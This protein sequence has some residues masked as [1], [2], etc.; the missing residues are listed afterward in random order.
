MFRGKAIVVAGPRQV[1]KTT[2]LKQITENKDIKSLLLNCDDAEVRELLVDINSKEIF[3]LIGSNRIVMID[4]AQ[5]VK[6]IGLTIKQ[7]VDNMPDLQLI[8]TGSSSLDLANEIN[9]PLTG[10]K[11][12]Y[13]LFPFSVK[14]LVDSSNSLIEKQLLENRLIFGTYP[15][16]VNHP[17]EE[18]E[19]LLNIAESYLYKDILA[20]SN[21]RKP[22]QLEKL[23]TALA[24]QIGNEVSYNEL[25]QTVGANVETIERYIDLLEQCYVVFKQVAFSRNLRNEIKKSKKIYFYD[26]GIRNALISNFS[27]LALRQDTGQLWENYFVVERTKFNHY[28]LNFTKS[29]FWRTFQQQEIDLVEEIDEKLTCFEMKWNDKRNTRF[30]V[31]FLNNYPVKNQHIVN[32]KN[33]MDFL[34]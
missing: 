22:A 4:E 33:Y 17:G 7:V 29:Y 12:V 6:N 28:S 5:R 9:E 27:P 23:L 3:S 34:I 32:R 30:P 21:I 11:Y 24:L 1:G 2:L 13:H 8:V 14:E 25:A 26:N 15:D 10:R 16:V 20:L 31:T 19:L 18:R